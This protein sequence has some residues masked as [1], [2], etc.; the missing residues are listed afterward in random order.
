MSAAKLLGES[1][2]SSLIA[3]GI[4]LDDPQIEWA[5]AP[6]FTRFCQD[7]WEHIDPAI[8]Q[9]SWHMDEICEALEIIAQKRAAN[10]PSDL[11]VN[12]PPGSTKSRITSVLWQPWVWSWWPES[13][14]ITASYDDMLARRLSELSLELIRGAWYQSRW[15]V[16]LTRDSARHFKNSLGGERFAVGIGSNITGAHGHFI[17]GDDL[18]KEQLARLG[19]V[20]MIADAVARSVGYWFG[21]L[22]TR[23]IDYIAGRVLIHQRLHHDDPSGVAIQKHNYDSIVFPG[24]Y[25]LT[26]ADPK[27]HRTVDGEIL[28]DRL[29]EKV[30]ARVALEIGPTAASGQIE[31]NPIPPGGQLLKAE[32]MIHRWTTLPAELIRSMESSQ[33]SN[34]QSWIISGDLAFKGRRQS[35]AKHGPDYTVLQLWCAH[36]PNRYLIDEV[37]GQFSFREAKLQL[38]LFA[39]RYPVTGTIILEDAANAAAVEDDLTQ[40]LSSSDLT[41]ILETKGVKVSPTWNPSIVLEP[42]GGGTL[43]RTQS[44]EGVWHSGTVI[45]PANALWVDSPGGFVDE[46]LRYSG[47]DGETDDRVSASSLA[48]L[49]LKDDLPDWATYGSS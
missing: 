6:P 45:L 30:M 47:A 10:N 15:P 25:D 44:V 24:H 49:H 35:K 46:H 26:R 41:A 1:A 4:S 33:W 9:W 40:G 13:K 8:L 28:C 23:A 42:H 12:V 20:N 39:L 27:D 22:S 48:L 21:T 36:G 16:R 29:G 14:W 18:I 17:V 3:E 37:R 34:D 7:A 38:A 43:A 32:Y 31:Q 2:K 5:L 19:S 11:A